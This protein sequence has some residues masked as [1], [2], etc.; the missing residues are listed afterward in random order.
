MVGG[1]LVGAGPGFAVQP[2]SARTTASEVPAAITDLKPVMKKSPPNLI[3]N[4][5]LWRRIENV[6]A[7]L[8]PM[9][10]KAPKSQSPRHSRTPHEVKNDNRRSPD[11]RRSTG[12][13]CRDRRCLRPVH[14]GG[15][16]PQ[17]DVGCQLEQPL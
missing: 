12:R 3:P 7:A 5:L 6:V 16:G 13:N 4:L 1:A 17:A 8:E 10:H 9:A 11:R 15:S 2:T 14:L